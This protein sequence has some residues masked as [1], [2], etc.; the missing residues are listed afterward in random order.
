MLKRKRQSDEEEEEEEHEKHD[1]EE[2]ERDSDVQEREED[3]YECGAGDDGLEAAEG[4]QEHVIEEIEQA[5]EEKNDCVESELHEEEQT[6][7]GTSTEEAKK[8]AE[9]AFDQSS[10][11]KIDLFEIDP[12]DAAATLYF[13]DY[14][15]IARSGIINPDEAVDDGQE[16]DKTWL[17]KQVVEELQK[18]WAEMNGHL[19]LKYHEM[20]TTNKTK[21]SALKK[22]A[23]DLKRK[24]IKDKI[25]TTLE[26]AKQDSVDLLELSEDDPVAAHYY[27]SHYDDVRFGI[28][29]S[30]EVDLFNSWPPNSWIG[31]KVIGKLKENWWSFNTLQ[32]QKLSEDLKVQ[33]EFLNSDKTHSNKH[34]KQFQPAAKRQ[35]VIQSRKANWAELCTQLWILISSFWPLHHI[36][37]TCVTLHQH[38]SLFD[39]QINQIVAPIIKAEQAKLGFEVW[40]FNCRLEA[41][42]AVIGGSWV[43]ACILKAFVKEPTKVFKPNDMDIYAQ[44]EWHKRR[45]NEEI[46]VETKPFFKEIAD[47]MG[48]K[49]VSFMNVMEDTTEAE[50]MEWLPQYGIGENKSTLD[51][52]SQIYKVGTIDSIRIGINKIQIIVVTC[53]SANFVLDNYDLSCL[54]NFWDGNSVVIRDRAAI[55]NQTLDL[56]P[57]FMQ[58]RRPLLDVCGWSHLRARFKKYMDRG[59]TVAETTQAKI[60]QAFMK[61]SFEPSPFN[62]QKQPVAKLKTPNR[63]KSCNKLNCKLATQGKSLF[64]ILHKNSNS[65]KRS[66]TGQKRPLF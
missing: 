19:K 16:H 11:D 14:Y 54:V 55:S 9:A 12:N 4:E 46:K 33:E 34:N 45:R 36:A 6:T 28:C 50:I 63:C 7:E 23:D 42:Q 25:N 32:K 22:D 29:T 30:Q 20:V 44:V 26:K 43:L 18:N 38:R 62:K 31:N 3:S 60:F 66:S 24:Q 21:L 13:I 10:M 64:D 59:F 5:Q 27:I 51:E 48:R 52:M 39:E 40:R 15:C 37:D 35:K 58:L 61:G 2:T 49:Y 57:E 8:E 65:L 47:T 17:G 53:K 1:Q 56:T 41:D